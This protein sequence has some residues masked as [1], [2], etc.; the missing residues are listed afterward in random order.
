MNF[1]DLCLGFII[2]LYNLLLYS[3][4]IWF[5]CIVLSKSGLRMPLLPFESFLQ[6]YNSE[7]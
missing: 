4:K 6:L 2:L 1:S 3:Y 7:I 5:L